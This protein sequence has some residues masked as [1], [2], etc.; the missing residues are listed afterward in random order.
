M[1][2]S[3]SSPH[4]TLT[5]SSLHE[6]LNFILIMLRSRVLLRRLKSTYVRGGLG[7]QS[8]TPPIDEINNVV[9]VMDSDCRKV[10][11]RLEFKVCNLCDKDNKDKA[12]NL[13]KL[14]LNADGS[15]HCFRCA[16]HGSFNRL[17]QIIGISKN[18]N[19]ISNSNNNSVNNSYNN[20]SSYNISTNLNYNNNKKNNHNYHN[21]NYNYNNNDNDNMMMNIVNSS[22][23]NQNNNN[24]N[25]IR[26]QSNVNVSK[27]KLPDQKDAYLRT[28]SL[29]LTAEQDPTGY[30]ER[31]R[32]YLTDTRGLDLFTCKRFGVGF[33]LQQW[34]NDQGT[35]EDELCVTFPWM[36]AD[37]TNSSN[38]NSSNNNSSNNNSS[39]TNSSSDNRSNKKLKTTVEVSPTKPIL[40]ADSI[41]EKTKNDSTTSSNTTTTTTATTTTKPI[42]WSIKRV[43]YR[44]M[45]G[46]GK[47][48]LHPKGGQWGLFGMHTVR[49]NTKAIV[50]TEGEFDC[51]AVAQAISWGVSQQ[52][53]LKKQKKFQLE[54]DKK[55]EK[56]EKFKQRHKNATLINDTKSDINT[57]VDGDDRFDMEE[58]L[59]AVDLEHLKVVSLPNGCNSLPPDVLPLLERFEKIYLWMDNDEAGQ[60]A[61]QK[62][63]MKLGKHRVHCIR[64]SHAHVGVGVGVGGNEK[65]EVNVP[66]KDANDLLR[67]AR[68]INSSSTTTS[69]TTTDNDGI[70]EYAILKM[71]ATAKGPSHE[72]VQS[73]VDLKD[74]VLQYLSQPPGASRADGTPTPSLPTL[75]K[76]VKGFRRGE[77]V[78]FTGPTGG[79]KTTLL[80]QLSIDWAQQQ[81]PTLW[82][83][84][85]IR[86]ERLLHK[87]LV[88][89]HKHGEIRGLNPTQLEEIANNFGKLPLQFMN[90]HGSSD[91]DQVLEAMR[92]AVYKHDIEHIIIDNLQFMMP[93][94]NGGNNG[95]NNGV[96]MLANGF[97]RFDMQDIAIDRFR[98]FASEQ[99][100]N[101]TL[102]IHPRKED[103]KIPLG[104]SSIF[105][106]AKATQE[107]DVVLILQ[108]V[109]GQ[110]YLEVK[111]NR[112][113]GCTG[114]IDMDFS[115]MTNCFFENPPAAGVG[116]GGK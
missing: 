24:N 63:S 80:S 67:N 89:S 79:G 22:S 78:I 43:K 56:K 25:S 20:K 46:K 93:R 27:K 31:V 113:D 99:D 15:Y 114:K 98:Q 55:N 73:W 60:A 65:E 5:R 105:G 77:L 83:S 103:D 13:W 84:F 108:R 49:E 42:S 53:K 47:Q 18:N 40:D 104:L 58:I 57:N 29:D 91:L 81:M 35:W 44:S 102:V 101:V 115:T 32:N 21:K 69:T 111:K 39:D 12:D 66:F 82:G 95:N 100:V 37:N 76:I 7:N 19:N 92:F 48:R 86:N 88:Q 38:N 14:W 11:D 10:G 36:T 87:M 72:K 54:Q 116:I 109:Q 2:F 96:R 34:P 94:L 28:K 106:T 61:V 64:Q 45:E 112:Y 30:A 33:G 26:Y 6:Y 17:K 4:T 68:K 97:E 16:E 59:N 23:F 71:L 110:T 70:G 75:T 41:H 90:F 8:Y 85:E 62:F 1:T 3:A 74:S 9:N 52:N 51:L 50:L 107:A